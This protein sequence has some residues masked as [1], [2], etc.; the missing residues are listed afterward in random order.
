MQEILEILLV[1][2]GQ[3]SFEQCV[4]RVDDAVDPDVTFEWCLVDRFDFRPG[5]A[6]HRTSRR[7]L[8]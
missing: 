5:R 1:I 6:N 3:L 2:F 7:R 4:E 8:R